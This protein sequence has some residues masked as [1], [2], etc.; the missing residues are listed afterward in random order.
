MDINIHPLFV[1]FPIALLSIYALFELAGLTPL[2]R[3]AHLVAVKKTFLYLGTLGILATYQ[4]GLMAERLLNAVGTSAESLVATHKWWAWF[5]LVLFC[6]LSA[7]YMIEWHLARKSEISARLQMAL[8]IVRPLL[9]FAGLIAILATGALG[10]A[11]V[12][13]PEAEPF[14]KFIYP[15][16]VK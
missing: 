4:T 9:A 11:I 12:Y 3:W 6:A 13:G 14:I 10:G 5:T 8:A 2:K 1:H 15:Y 16:L 7:M